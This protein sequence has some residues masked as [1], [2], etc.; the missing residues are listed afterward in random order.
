V[1]QDVKISP[2]GLQVAFGVRGNTTSLEL[3]SIDPSSFA[4][5]SAASIKINS[6]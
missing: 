1:V 6:M 4:L 3:V 2:D 5:K